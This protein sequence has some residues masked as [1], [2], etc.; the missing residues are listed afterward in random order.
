MSLIKWTPMS[1]DPFD[2][3]D[4]FFDWPTLSNMRSAGFTPALDVWQ[5]NENVYV[6]CPLAGVNPKEVSVSVENDVLTVKGK[7]EQKTEVDEKNYYR[8]EVRY[9]AFHRT[10]ALPASINNDKISAIFENGVLKITLPKEE[11]VK[12]KKIDVKI[13]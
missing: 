10:V 3:M 13:K 12:P 4:R 1:I 2:E 5:D 8:K 7:S 11:R 6:E 9:G